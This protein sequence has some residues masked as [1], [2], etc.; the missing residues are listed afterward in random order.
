MQT[1]STSDSA[2]K[3]ASSDQPRIDATMKSSSVEAYSKLFNT[4]YNIVVHGKPF[5]DFSYIVNIQKENGVQLLKGKQN[6]KLCAVMTQF[7]AESI[8]DKVSE[9]VRLSACAYSILNDGS[10]PKKTGG[11]L[12]LIYI[13]VLGSKG[14]PCYY[15]VGLEELAAHGGGD[16]ESIKTA[17]DD[18]FLQKIKLDG[19]TYR[20]KCISITADG[21]SVNTGKYNGIFTQFTKDRP[22]LLSIHCVAN[23][24]E[25]AAKRCL[26]EKCRT[27]GSG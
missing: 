7:I 20:D 16:T 23:R 15:C 25:L 21:A 8:Q 2:L 4:A 3:P 6:N 1:C 17:I 14:L 11:D 26:Y 9:I 10:Q 18:T 13:R 12:E 22:W 19:S 5:I 24:A 27:Q